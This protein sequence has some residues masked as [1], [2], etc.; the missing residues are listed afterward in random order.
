M[1]HYC[2]GRAVIFALDKGANDSY[3]ETLRRTLPLEHF[4]PFILR[5]ARQTG[6][7]FKVA[8]FGANVGAVSL[9]LAANGIRVLAIEAVPENFIALATAARTNRFSNLLPVNMAA[10][11]SAG[12][13]S[14]AGTGPWATAG[15]GSGDIT[16]CCDTLV[17]ILEV[18]GFSDA[19]VVKLDIEG[20]ELRALKDADRF[21]DDRPRTEVI[22]E[23]NDHT[24][25]FFGYRRNDLLRWFEQR[26][27]SLYA[28]RPD[29][30]MPVKPDDPQP[31][32]VIDI[33]ATRRS[34]ASLEEQ[35]EKIVLMTEDY[36]MQELLKIS[37][38]TDPAIR[39]HFITEARQ[40]GE[41]ARRS[42]S[43]PD[44]ASAMM[45]PK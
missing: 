13:V 36:I 14:L 45:S 32:P 5:R 27:F 4:I 44:I 21:F 19:D 41:G 22:F 18:Y 6:A 20:A 42:A 11:D 31:V 28:F 35:G 24:C 30:L 2:D 25:Q 38:S 9:P 26:D 29:G 10:L 7:G 1:V 15:L 34:P 23:S 40:L 33:L 16:I 3:T 8:D 37:T 12:L 17:N 43:W 39:Q